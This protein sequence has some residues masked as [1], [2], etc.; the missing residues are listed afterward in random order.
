VVTLI[1]ADEALAAGTLTRRELAGR[2][3]KV[4]RNVYAPRGA[5]LTA[6]DRAVAAWM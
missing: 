3:V 1:M 4:H 2:F 5:E 6:A